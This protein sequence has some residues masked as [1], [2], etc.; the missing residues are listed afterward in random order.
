MQ[1]KGLPLFKSVFDLGIYQMLLWELKPKT[2][3]EIGAIN[4]GSAV[5][6]ADLLKS[7]GLECHVYS[8]DINIPC[9]QYE[10]VTFIQGDCN[11]IGT[12][13]TASFLSELPHPWL[14]IEDAHVNV[15]NVLSYFAR[16]M[17]SNDYLVVEDSG[18]KQEG[19]A[20]F[21][22]DKAEKFVVD[23]KYCDFFGRNM[24]CSHNSILKK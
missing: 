4:G 10:D 14:V 17:S 15:T 1:W 6:M 5:W 20:E 8:F 3:I 12:G 11:Q 9:F 16:Y 22:S 19:V 24:T 23:T 2:I 13:M 21:L 18:C 7:F